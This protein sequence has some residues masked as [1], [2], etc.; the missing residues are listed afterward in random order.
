MACGL[1]FRVYLLVTLTVKLLYTGHHHKTFNT[2]HKIF[3]LLFLLILCSCTKEQDAV[4]VLDNAKIYFTNN[5][6]NDFYKSTVYNDTTRKQS[7]NIITYTLRNPTDK[8]LLFAFNKEELFP[9]HSKARVV[10][11]LNFII[12]SKNDSILNFSQPIIDPAGNTNNDYSYFEG[13]LDGK[14]YDFFKKQ[15]RYETLNITG[16]IDNYINNSVILHSGESRTF[17]VIVT[18]PIIIENDFEKHGICP[19]YYENIMEGYTF[20]LIYSCNANALKNVLPKY[21]RDELTENEIEIYNGKLH[22][23]PAVLVLK[24]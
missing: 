14:T 2:M 21:L 10:Q 11:G 12:K 9:L 8:N 4:L 24:K 20:Q 22:S 17:K 3:G 23:N 7:T 18:L 1:K 13:Y 6:F 16:E 15:E 19:V 5:D